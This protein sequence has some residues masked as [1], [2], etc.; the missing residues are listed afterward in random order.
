M[1]DLIRLFARDGKI[2]T[3]TKRADTIHDTK[4]YCLGIT[5]LQIRHLLKRRMKHFGGRSTVNILPLSIRLDQMLIAR[6][7]R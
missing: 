6:H 5:A 3:K 7:M 4:V 1:N 2:L